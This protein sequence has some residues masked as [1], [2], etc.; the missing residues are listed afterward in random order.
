MDA[1]ERAELEALLNNGVTT[2]S[3][4][5]KDLLDEREALIAHNIDSLGTCVE[6]KKASVAALNQFE[7]S[8]RSILNRHSIV[9][10]IPGTESWLEQARIIC[11]GYPELEKAILLLGDTLADCFR[12][13]IENEGLV[14]LGLARVS[15]AIKMLEG[16]HSS[17]SLYN[18]DSGV[19]S[20]MPAPRSLARV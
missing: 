3:G 8:I 10:G 7:A 20:S 19:S 18:P 2:A 5:K 4:L 11:P 16:D 9:Q 15:K 17:T 14:N 13:S 6:R 12:Q 1:R